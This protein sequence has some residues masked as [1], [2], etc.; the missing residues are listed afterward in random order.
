MKVIPS[1]WIFKLKRDAEGRIVRYKC[2]LVAGGHRQ[3]FGIDYDETFAPVSK[4]TSLRVFLS[5]AAHNKWQVSQFDIKTA[6]LHGDLDLDV[7]M[8]QPEGFEEGT[9]LVCKLEKSLYGLKQAPRAW[10][11]KLTAFLTYIRNET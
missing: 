4:A 8:L 1:K 10:F 11:E 2:Q 9:G 7:Y 5:F 6:F 3:V